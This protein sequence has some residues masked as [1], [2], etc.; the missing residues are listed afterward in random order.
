M[1]ILWGKRSSTLA[2]QVSV[3]TTTTDLF[4]LERVSCSLLLY[5]QSSRIA[6]FSKSTVEYQSEPID[7]DKTGDYV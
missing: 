3:I 2:R 1:T 6:L 4:D 7:S 5:S